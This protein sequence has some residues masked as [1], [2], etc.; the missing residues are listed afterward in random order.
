MFPETLERT[1]SRLF[2]KENTII[3]INNFLNKLSYLS[4]L[5]LKLEALKLSNLIGTAF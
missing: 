1:K 5:P 2:T 4:A 3:E